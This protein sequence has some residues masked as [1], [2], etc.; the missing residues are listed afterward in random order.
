MWTY[1]FQVGPA[2]YYSQHSHTG[3]PN[4]WFGTRVNFEQ[5][6]RGSELS[7]GAV[8]GRGTRYGRLGARATRKGR[9]GAQGI[10]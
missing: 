6:V 9:L 8:R 2:N 4:S 10:R 3:L 7:V 1:L 5:V